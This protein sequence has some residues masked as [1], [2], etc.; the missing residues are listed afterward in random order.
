MKSNRLAPSQNTREYPD[1]SI[2]FESA[3]LQIKDD[4]QN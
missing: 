3:T 1:K 2:A 4:K